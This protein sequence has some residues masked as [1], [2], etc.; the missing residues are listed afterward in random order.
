M[1][2]YS[3]LLLVML[4]LCGN[5]L[6]ATAAETSSQK[7]SKYS[8]QIDT[9]IEKNKK[10]QA[11]TEQSYLCPGGKLTPQQ[12]AYQVILDL[13]FKKIDK[14]VERGLADLQSSP[15]KDIGK[16]GDTISKWFDAT[17]G[18]YNYRKK[19]EAVCNKTV[20]DEAVKHFGS[21]VT[22]NDTDGFVTGNIRCQKLIDLK[23]R[24]YKD[25]A[26]LLARSAIVQS[27]ALDK[28]DYLRK[29][30]DQYEKFLTKCT[31][32]LGQLTI[33]KDKWNVKTKNIQ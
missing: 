12:I 29:L 22:D 11:K 20:I 19:Y 18:T 15:T 33:I 1:K 24:A 21:V 32:Y 2:K 9:C 16:V 13:E 26:W 10:G 5:I 30:K 23:L 7:Q 3:T 27:Y 17:T 14:E 8:G 4:F 25:A 6:M 31:V 28:H